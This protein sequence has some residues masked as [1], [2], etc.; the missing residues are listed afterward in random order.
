MIIIMITKNRWLVIV[1]VAHARGTHER[2]S[3]VGRLR[4]EMVH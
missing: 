4:V 1:A 2:E 3:L